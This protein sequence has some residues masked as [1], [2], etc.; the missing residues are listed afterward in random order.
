MREHAQL[1]GRTQHYTIYDQGDMRRVLDW[2]LADKE[3]A[4]VHAALGRCGQPASSE[5]QS[6]LSLAKNE[7]LSPEAIRSRARYGAAELIAVLWTDSEEGAA[8]LERL[9]LRRSARVRPQPPPAD[10]IVEHGGSND[11]R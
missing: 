10:S 11:P 1:F 8:P 2:I 3:R 4:A 9:G 5:V 7:L 6:A